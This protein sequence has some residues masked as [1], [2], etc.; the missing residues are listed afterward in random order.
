MEMLGGGPIPTE[1]TDVAEATKLKRA[2]KMRAYPTQGQ[3]GRARQ[4]LASHC[5]MY[6]AALDERK[7]AWTHPSKPHITYRT[8]SAQLREIRELCPED[9]RWSFT[10][11]QQTLRRLDRAFQAFFRR[12]RAGEAPG[13]PRFRSRA[14]FDTVDHVNGDGAK[15]TPT[16]GRWARAYFQGVGTLKVSEHTPVV[17]RV[18]QLSLKREG[19]RWYVIAVAEAEVEPLAETG[20]CVGIDVGIARFLVSSDAE[21]VDNP[22]FLAEAAHELA[23]HQQ[24]LGYER[25]GAAAKAGLNRVIHDAGWSQFI[26]VLSGKAAWAGRR[27]I[28]V[29]PAFTSIDCARCGAKQTRPTQ[30]V[31]VCPNCG[32]A[33]ADYN[34]PLNILTRAGLGSGQVSAHA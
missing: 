25:N 33:D 11:Q 24:V 34:A 20:H 23:R 15:W 18:T 16:Q 4:L 2:Y 31:V 3:V 12:V 9:A 17:G 21:I 26:A 1:G 27:M 22:R 10:A 19:R 7:C 6:N 5:E 13:Y 28:P 32:E 29:N 8:Q 14:R 30:A